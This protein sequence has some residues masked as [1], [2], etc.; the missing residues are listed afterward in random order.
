VFH[1]FG[2]K[3]PEICESHAVGNG[4]PGDFF[5]LATTLGK[6]KIDKAEVKK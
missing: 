1:W 2:P 4:E 6:F 5:N 3:V